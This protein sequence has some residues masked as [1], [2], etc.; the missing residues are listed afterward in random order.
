MRPLLQINVTDCIGETI[1]LI[2]ELQSISL[3]LLEQRVEFF[4]NRIGV[5]T[6]D[7]DG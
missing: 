1:D 5:V 3:H 4:A 2:I 7:H 6:F